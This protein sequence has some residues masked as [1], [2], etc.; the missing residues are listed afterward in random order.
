MGGECMDEW[1]G[2]KPDLKGCQHSSKNILITKI[3]FKIRKPFAA[4]KR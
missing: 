1:M 2:V 4:L 3:A